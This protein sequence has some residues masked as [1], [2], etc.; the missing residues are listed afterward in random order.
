[1]KNKLYAAFL[2]SFLLSLFQQLHAAAPTTQASNVNISWKSQTAASITWTRGNGSACM[3]VMRLN[4]SAGYVPASPSTTNYS[5]SSN[6]GS[7][8]TVNGA[9][10]NYIVYKGTGSSVFITGLT[11]NTLYDAYVY[12]YNVTGSTYYYNTNYAVSSVAVNTLA[13]DPS[14]CGG[15]TSVSSITNS[16]ANIFFTA[17]GGSGRMIT[18]APSGSS[19]TTPSDGYY[20]AP[21]AT[22]GNGGQLGGAYSIYAS[23]GT[24]TSVS[25][26]AGATTYNVY[27]YEYVNGTSPTSSSYN[28]NSRNYT[29]CNSYSFSTTNMP[30]TISAISNITICENSGLQF[31]SLAGITDGSTN[32]NQSLSITAVSNN[33]SLIANPGVSYSSPGQNGYLVITPANG[34]YGTATITVTVND[35]WSSNNT[36]STSFMVTVTPFPSAAGAISGPATVCAGGSNQTYSISP[37]ANATGYTWSLP[38]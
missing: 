33:T 11:A 4:S 25:G 18:V 5:A 20:Y 15:I 3:V 1:M 8:S 9:V 7:G 31:I 36:T 35:G 38:A 37:V 14:S 22:F 6:Y 10:D 16:S 28:Y 19:A 27:D 17:G 26:L 2:I 13:A 21:S 29:S 34:M 23:S 12:E 32:E 30:P 24:S